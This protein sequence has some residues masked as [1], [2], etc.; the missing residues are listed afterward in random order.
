LNGG[1]LSQGMS[2]LKNGI[3]IPPITPFEQYTIANPYLLA[4][5]R[6]HSPQISDSSIQLF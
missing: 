3:L 1:I 2:G 6:A 5:E 4:L